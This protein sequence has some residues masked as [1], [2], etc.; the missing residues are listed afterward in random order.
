MHTRR[1]FLRQSAVLGGSVLAAPSIVSAQ[2]LGLGGRTGA[3]SRINVAFIGM[4]GQVKALLGVT[5]RSDVQA[6]AVCDVDATRLARAKNDINRRGFPD[7]IATPDYED[8][9]EDPSVDAVVIV[10]PDHWHAAISL[11]AM[12]AGKDVYVEKPMT[13]TIE[14]G[15]IMVEA[16]KRYGSIIQVGSMQRSMAGFHKAAEMVR[17]GWIGDIEEIYVK[18]DTFEPAVLGPEEPIPEGFNYDKWL[19]PAPYEPYTSERVRGFYRGGWRRFWEYGSRKNG[20]WGA[21]HFDIVQWALG[22]DDSGPTFFMPAGYKGE[23]YQYHQYANGLKVIRD[24]PELKGRM[25]RFKGTKGDVFASRGHLSTSI[26]GMDKRPLSSSDVRLYHS[27][28]HLGNW[29]DCIKTRQTPICPATIGHRTGT[30]CQLAGIAERLHRPIKW[31]PKAERI[32]DDADALRWMD[33]PRRAGY[34]L[35]A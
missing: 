1:S 33:R 6:V 30:I 13:L 12:K 26:P 21:H 15:K 34:E 9:I 17:N 28:N 5:T 10:T 18:L 8:I 25:V 32:L 4:G 24:H 35:P 23:K 29:V 11:A 19:G 27:R 31:D 3:N 20:D 16:E 7:A 2:T 22:M 14:E